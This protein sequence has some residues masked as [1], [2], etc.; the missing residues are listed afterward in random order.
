MSPS[1]LIFLQQFETFEFLNVISFL[2]TIRQ[3]M[4][5]HFSYFLRGRLK[6]TPEELLIMTHLSRF[7]QDL[8]VKHRNTHKQRTQ[9]QHQSKL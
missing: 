5:Q 7:L 6:T 1:N 9:P 8:T 4:H 2:K 3:T